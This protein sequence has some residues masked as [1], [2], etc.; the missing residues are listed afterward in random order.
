LR[1][2]A[3]RS[4]NR[5]A[6]IVL[7]TIIAALKDI[8]VDRSREITVAVSVEVRILPGAGKSSAADL[9][10]DVEELSD[11]HRA[12]LAAVSAGHTR[13]VEIQ[14]AVGLK[15]RRVADLLKDL[16]ESGHLIQPKYGHYE[17]AA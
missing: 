3:K 1:G 14:R 17:A 9:D 5:K 13:P 12:V 10:G 11:S 7:D 2:R 6:L 15:H 16:V 8:D 4:L